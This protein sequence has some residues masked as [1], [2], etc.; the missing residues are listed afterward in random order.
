M[1]DQ[2]E[3]I[4]T[5]IKKATKIAV[6]FNKHSFGDSIASALAIF[7]FLQ[8]LGKTVII[9]GEQTTT[10]FN[11][12]PGY[13]QIINQLPQTN[14]FIISLKTNKTKIA[15]VNYK[16]REQILDFIITTEQGKFTEHDV[17]FSN[18]SDYDLIISLNSPDLESLG[19]LY[20]D[21]TDFFYQT[22]IINIDNQ[23]ANESYGQIN[24]INLN[25]VSTTE[26]IF[27]LL[28]KHYENLIDENIATCLLTGIIS[29]TKSFK[30][31]N[32]TPQTLM[33]VSELIHLGGQREKIITHLYRN[34]H[35]GV[36]QLWGRTLLN[37]NSLMNN[38]VI[39][40]V[41]Q[42]EDFSQTNTKPEDL[43][44]I[45]DELIISI[46]QALIIMLVIQSTNNQTSTAII[47]S[48]KNINCLSLV[49]EYNPQGTKH[50]VQI[51]IDKPAQQATKQLEQLVE[52]KLSKLDL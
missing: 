30:T 43:H 48:I 50:L 22:P 5:Q 46:P 17:E 24:L 34:K 20:Q 29:Q 14:K 27:N 52:A 47:R 8:K 25:A 18:I 51:T 16:T 37:L 42:P 32:V 45:I 2:T 31:N 13:N 19:Q 44:D 49:K 35:I 11:F 33:A 6:L 21:N 7:L 12:L 39:W 15:Q 10:G 3:Q 28:M 26:I 38:K 36:L 41:L 9:A 40:S 1:L 4:F 23:S